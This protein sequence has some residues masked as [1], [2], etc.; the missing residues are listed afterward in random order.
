MILIII[1]I[2]S[3]AAAEN[4]SPENKGAPINAIPDEE[5]YERKLR[6]PKVVLSAQRSE[7]RLADSVTQVE[8]ITKEQIR[9]KGARTLTEVLNN[10]TGFFIQRNFAGDNVQMQGL[11]SQ[12][13]LIL[14]DGER[15]NGRINGQ[16]DTGR[17]RVEN[18]ERVEI[19]RGSSSAIYGSDAIAGVVNIITARPHKGMVDAKLQGGNLGAA[20]ATTALVVPLGDFLVRGSAAYRTQQPYRYDDKMVATLGRGINEYGFDSGVEWDF[21]R[22]WRLAV[23][24][25]YSRRR[26][27]GID[28]PSS[29]GIFDRINLTETAQT[30]FRLHT[31]SENNSAE[32]STASPVVRD[33]KKLAH[34]LKADQGKTDFRINGSY[35]VFR[36]QFLYDQRGDTALD[37]YENTREN[38]YVLHA[39]VATRVL[40]LGRLSLGSEG[41]FENLTTPRIQPN[42][43]DRHRIAGYAQLDSRLAENLLLSPGFRYDHDSQFGDYY[44]P[45]FGA[46]WGDQDFIVRLS[47]GIGYRSPSFRELYLYFE[48]PSAGYTVQGNSTLRPE[49]SRSVNLGVEWYASRRVSIDSNAYYN[50]LT[51]LIQTGAAGT[52]GPVTQYSYRNVARALTAGSDNRITIYILRY[53]KTT[54]GYSFTFARDLALDRLLEGR[55]QHRVHWGLYWHYRGWNVRTMVSLIDRRPYYIDV[56]GAPPSRAPIYSPGYATVDVNL[57]YMLMNGFSFFAGGENLNSAGDPR[58]LPLPPARMYA[59]MRY[60]FGG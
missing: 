54:L 36:D 2:K 14:R 6:H 5:V 26:L 45:R 24:G 47:F 37:N 55:P 51:N 29:G 30:S 18:I 8:V 56:S 43:K 46:K 1:L 15:L 33:D 22:N 58:Y 28:T 25:D 9:E 31:R 4:Q 7:S 3:T 39:Q 12:Y 50:D 41:I 53:L 34:E 57:E 11:D 16:Y 32:N 44:S 49:T 52:V 17:L 38:T 48:N 23:Q 13:L 40:S 20:D 60:L 10:E 35:T 21:A 19:V 42:Y 59:G 27:W